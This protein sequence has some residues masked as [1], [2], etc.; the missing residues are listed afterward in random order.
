MSGFLRGLQ[1]APCAG[2]WATFIFCGGVPAFGVPLLN[3][4]VPPG[5]PIAIPNYVVPLFGKYLCFALLA[6]SLD[7]IWGYAGPRA[8]GPSSLW[9]AIA[10]VCT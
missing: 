5:S 9:A 1:T 4:G 6:L 8:R 3:S 2:F 10:W 7:L